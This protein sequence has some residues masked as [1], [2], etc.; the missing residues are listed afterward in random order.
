[1][2]SILIGQVAVISGGVGDIGRAIGLEL[3]RRGA[4]IAL[5]DVLEPEKAGPLLRQIQ[6]LGRRG[7][8]DPVDVS[9]CDAVVAWIDAVERDLGLPTLIVAN[10]AV[11]RLQR[12]GELTP[13]EWR[14]ELA[15]NLDGSFY[16][17]HAAVRRLMDQ[18]KPGRVVFIGSWAAHA[19]HLHIP[20][21]CVSK[22]GLR[23][24]CKCMAAE[25]AP[26]NILVNEV[27]PGYVDAGLSKRIWD[28]SP[29]AREHARG[30]VPVRRLISADEVAA[31][32]AHLCEP[33]NVHMTGSTLLMD[34]GLSLFGCGGYRRD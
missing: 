16:M 24:L 2:S 1:M 28:E 17:A 7:R 29:H 21:Y 31:Q 5:C 10:A 8:Y 13:A 25:L 12:F 26:H 4:D 19:V 34:G 32:V 30:V 23:M 22:A 18:K 33:E 14:R 11:V 15:V 9:D 3:A 20:A 6:S 27:A